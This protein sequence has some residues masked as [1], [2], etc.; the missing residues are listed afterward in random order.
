MEA[1]SGPVGVEALKVEGAKVEEEERAV[2]VPLFFSLRS[3][4]ESPRVVRGSQA[5][6][7][8]AVP[9]RHG[10]VQAGPSLEPVSAA[11]TNSEDGRT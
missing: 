3:S 1:L 2:R 5:E 7:R 11:G 4:L 9:L 6:R 10:Q 8:G